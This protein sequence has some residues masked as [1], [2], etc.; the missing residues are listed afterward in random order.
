MPHDR[1]APPPGASGQQ[2]PGPGE[3][4][5]QWAEGFD[6]H[7]PMEYERGGD[8]LRGCLLFALVVG[9]A[10]CAI[11]AITLSGGVEMIGSLQ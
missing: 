10:L 3:P 5:R 2:G 9:I 11:A 7:A 1:K 8:I 4:A 6:P